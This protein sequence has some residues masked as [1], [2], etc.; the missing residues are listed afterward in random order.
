M[1]KSL[2][3]ISLCALAL[4]VLA[5]GAGTAHASTK[6]VTIMQDDGLLFRQGAAVRDQTLNE[7]QALGVDVIKAQVFWNEI[8][9]RGRTKPAGFDGADPASYDFSA[10]DGL[11][12]AIV[13]R[14]MT[15]FLTIG[16][17]APDWAVKK[18]T[19]A[20]RDG[21]Y[22]PSSKE[23]R[24]FAEAVGRRYSGDYNGLPRVELWS[25][26]N[27]PNLAS[28]LAPQ[29][30]RKGVPVA[31]SL[32]RKLYLAGHR[33]LA[34][35]GHARDKI[36]LGE[37]MPLGAGSKSKF[38][39]TDFLREMVCL[40]RA[41]RPYRGK[42]AKARGCPKRVARIPTSGIA[43]HPYTPRAGLSARPRAGEVPITRLATMTRQLDLLGRRAK[44]PR[45]LPIWLTEFGF[46]TNPPDPFQTPIKRVPGMMDKSEWIAFRNRRVRSYSQ[47]TMR[48][49]GLVP[50]G[51]RFQRYAGFQMGLRFADGRVKKGVY[52]AFRMP[53]FVRLLSSRRVE[54]FGGLRTG[55]RAVARIESRRRGGRYRPLGTAR[56]S[57]AGY[58]RK[59]LSASGAKNR[60]Y[61]V[62]ISGHRRVKKPVTP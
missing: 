22:R 47:Y 46:Q 58:F 53:V 29:R 17:R 62:T 37:L 60:T 59:V 40:D 54:V 16:N 26:W 57:S 7:M 27:E 35:S 50:G 19:K 55:A 33:G 56:L 36:L 8:A 9:P 61:R 14:G 20:P 4:A 32:Y 12:N 13:A 38:T 10:Y 49:A 6:Q 11:V 48:D 3:T 41:Y 52:D 44:L 21:M 42:A 25:I 43:L 15:P 1:L 45:R 24:L 18:V 30:T 23:F 39:P 31:P 34:A 51:S 5:A 28:W 2:R